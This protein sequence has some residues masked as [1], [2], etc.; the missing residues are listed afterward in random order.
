MEA[1]DESPDEEPDESHLEK[2]HTLTS[3]LLLL[4]ISEKIALVG[5]SFKPFGR[6]TICQSRWSIVNESYN[7]THGYRRWLW[8]MTIEDDY[9]RPWTH[10]KV[11]IWWKVYSTLCTLGI[12]CIIVCII[13]EEESKERRL[14]TQDSGSKTLNQRLSVYSPIF[15]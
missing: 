4:G 1:P 14:C 7:M 12:V 13:D 3:N 11:H 10:C 6:S 2:L 5:F 15:S 9:Q 8:L